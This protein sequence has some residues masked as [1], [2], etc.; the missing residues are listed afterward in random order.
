MYVFL[1]IALALKPASM[2]F[3]EATTIPSRTIIALQGLR[4]KRLIQPRQI[5]MMNGAG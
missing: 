1:K 4:D 2:T 3:K 5:V